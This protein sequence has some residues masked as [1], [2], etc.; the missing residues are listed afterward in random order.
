MAKVR[1]YELA[2]ELD[3]KPIPLFE[4]IKEM[5][6]EVKSHMSSLDDDVVLTVRKNLLGRKGTDK[7]QDK[8]K[9]IIIL[10]FGRLFALITSTTS[11]GFA[12]TK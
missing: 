9:K 7:N 10:S 2:K 11:L 12:L 1:V 6:F 3:M 5:G 8:A 4:K